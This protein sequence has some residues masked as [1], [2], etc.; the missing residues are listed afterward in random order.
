[1]IKKFV[2]F[3]KLNSTAI[4]IPIGIITGLFFTYYGDALFKN[5]ENKLSLLLIG[6]I[7]LATQIFLVLFP[8]YSL[9]KQKKDVI[10]NL[11]ESCSKLLFMNCCNDDWEVCGMIQVPYKN[12]RRTPYYTN[13]AVNPA[14]RNH[15][16]L[17]FGDIG[18]AFF[19]GNKSK[20]YLSE[21]LPKDLWGSK[22]P[23]YKNDVPQNLRAIF[24]AAIFSPDEVDSSTVIGVLEFDIFNGKNKNDMSDKLYNSINTTNNK[25][26][27]CQWAKSIAILMEEI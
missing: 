17:N 24:A 27:L 8:K 2:K 25:N 5:H 13:S 1:M 19:S 11:L 14:I 6:L 12:T 3:I 26:A 10:N 15:R 21:R 23:K 18:K 20:T 16:K 22:P 7:S 4:Q 9:K